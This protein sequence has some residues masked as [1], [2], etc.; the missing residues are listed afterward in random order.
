MF[1]KLQPCRIYSRDRAVAAKS[2]SQCFR[3]T[4]H[5][6]CGVHA[7]TGTTGRTCLILIFTQILIRDLSCRMRSYRLEHA[8]KTCT[9]ALYMTGKHGTAADEDRRDIDAGC[10]HQKPRYV[11]ITIGDHHKSVKLMC[12]RQRFRGVRDQISCNK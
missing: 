11:F 12:H 7:G 10:R 2:H 1:R 8:G 5:A 6:V 9:P 3:Q 4:V